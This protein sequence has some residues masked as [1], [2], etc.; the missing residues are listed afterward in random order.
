META[1]VPLKWLRS[2]SRSKLKNRQNSTFAQ[3]LSCQIGSAG[4]SWSFS[5][6]SFV[7][8]LTQQILLFKSQ[9][10]LK[11]QK[12]TCI[13]IHIKMKYILTQRDTMSLTVTRD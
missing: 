7:C 6:L 10:A 13:M 8:T 3:S 12:S 11:N 9:K 1:L 4:I 5:S 2:L